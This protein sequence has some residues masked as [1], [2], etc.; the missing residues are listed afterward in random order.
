MQGG[1]CGGG[2]CQPNNGPIAQ[3]EPNNN[4]V[5]PN[6]A[7]HRP[8]AGSMD[9]KEPMSV[10]LYHGLYKGF[11][12][13]GTMDG[14]FAHAFLVLSWNLMCC[15]KNTASI[16]MSNVRWINFDC[17]EIFFGHSKT[18]LLGDNAKYPCHLFANPNDPL[19]CP[20][21]ALSLY[22]SCCFNTNQ[23]SESS[24]FP[25]NL[26]HDHFKELLTQI[27]A[28]HQE[29]V[30]TLGY[31]DGDLGA[32]S[33]CKGA[34]TFISL[35][36]RGPPPTAIC[37]RD[38]WTMGHVKDVYM[39]YATAGD[40][41][42]G[43]CLCLLPL[44]QT[45]FGISPPHFGSWVGE[46]L[47]QHAVSS[48]FS[49]V[50]QIEGFGKMCCMCLV[51]TLYHCEYIS[52]FASNHIAQITSYVFCHAA[53][54]EFFTENLDAVVTKIT[55]ED[56]DHHFSR[57]PPHLTALHELMEV[58]TEQHALVDKFIDRMK[59]VLDEQGIEGGNLTMVQLQA[60]IADGVREIRQRLDELEGGPL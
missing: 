18:D 5:V 59:V 51:S 45:T 34:I 15:A 4:G 37:I 22:F 57:I 55:W 3:P 46:A 36:P 49:M 53:M 40:E 35:L 50:H 8:G 28:E 12:D 20:V 16:K 32:H 17:F 48:Q 58:N 21:V 43:Q 6:I 9:G 33:I 38:G 2:Q 30:I 39:R 14:V 29:E 10:K 23:T 26:Q 13:W 1:Y 25:G 42:V 44:L 56:R 19:V 27:L 54:L 24:L 7:P 11:F 52:N 60:V 47:I 31:Q 41:F